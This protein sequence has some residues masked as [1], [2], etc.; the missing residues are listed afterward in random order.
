MKKYSSGVP[1]NTWVGIF[2]QKIAYNTWVGIFTKKI[3][4]VACN[5]I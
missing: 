5:K 2:T 3:L 1:Y 4:V